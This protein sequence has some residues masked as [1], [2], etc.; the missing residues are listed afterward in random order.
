MGSYGR[1]FTNQFSYEEIIAELKLEVNMRYG[2]YG[3]AVEN[4]KMS[5]TA[6]NEKI[7]KMKAAVQ[8]LEQFKEHSDPKANKQGRLAF[9]KKAKKDNWDI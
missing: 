9:A 5:L 1:D 6:K 4:G 2:V 7:A 8:Y 3:R